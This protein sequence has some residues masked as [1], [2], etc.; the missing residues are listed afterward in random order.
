MITMTT[1][2]HPAHAHQFVL[3]SLGTDFFVKIDR[4]KRGAGV[5]DT[6]QRTH[7]GREQSRHHDAAQS[8]RQ[9]VGDHQ[10]KCSLRGRWRGLA[11]GGI[12]DH[13]QLG[14]LA[15]FGQRKTNQTWNDE[16]IHGE[17]FQESGENA[18]APGRLFVGRAQGALHDVLV[19]TPIPQSNDRRANRHAQPGKFAVEIPRLLD[20]VA[21]WHS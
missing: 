7:Q 21:R 4:E 6:G 9:K 18:A 15:A 1:G 16:E 3:R 10:G 8:R 5:E 12:I 13:G 19:G 14:N 2:R 17:E 11:R 20:D